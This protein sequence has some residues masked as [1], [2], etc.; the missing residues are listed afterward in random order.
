MAGLTALS[1][2]SALSYPS[3]PK[4]APFL[5]LEEPLRSHFISGACI[6]FPVPLGDIDHRDAAAP[7]QPE[8]SLREPA[9][10]IGPCDE[11]SGR[12][13]GS[14]TPRTSGRHS[15]DRRRLG[16][17]QSAD[18]RGNDD[19]RTVASGPSLHRPYEGS[20]EGVRGGAQESEGL[21]WGISG[22]SRPRTRGFG[23]P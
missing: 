4:W 6:N 21:E 7:G 11:G 14:R 16:R 18:G 12:R 23:S 13:R 1:V 15:Q 19:G 2:P 20:H 5:F 8:E 9:V 17:G 10:G 22:R 3:C